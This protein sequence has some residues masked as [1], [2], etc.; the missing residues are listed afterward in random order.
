MPSSREVWGA[1]GS[2]K[3]TLWAL[4]ALMV[5]VVL[6]T[7]AQVNLGTLGAVNATMRTW[8]VLW[9][10]T[11]GGLGL[12]VFPGG[13]LVGL[14]LLVNLTAALI[15]RFKFTWR[16]FGLWLV[17]AGLVVLVGGEFVSGA[18]QVETRMTLEE[19]QTVS[20]LEHGRE[21]ELVLIDR[22][23]PAKDEEW[24][25]AEARLEKGGTV[26]LPGSSLSL[27]ILAF[28]RNAELRNRMPQDAPGVATAGIG[29]NLTMVPRPLIRSNEEANMPVALVEVVGAGQSHG[30]WLTSTALGAPQGFV[31]E[32]HPLS[33]ALRHRRIQLPFSLTLKD[34]KHDRYPGTDIPKNFS[35]LVHLNDPS[36]GQSRDI[37]ISMNQPMRYDGKAFYQASFD[38]ADT[39]SIFQVVENPGWLLP[40][41]STI[42]VSLGLLIHFGVMLRKAVAKRGGEA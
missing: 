10:P 37:L 7:F 29:P 24:G 21:V 5:L 40:Y 13:A 12:P 4:F 16:Q 34:F 1:L 23:N 6:C 38:K 19:G 35:S 9:H 20:H 30:V 42:L 39:V 11:E 33:I 2:L 31:H 18:L 27:K 3:L 26:A 28:H 25:I 15:Q 22:S 14:A 17:H 36:K 41:I 8:W 32:G